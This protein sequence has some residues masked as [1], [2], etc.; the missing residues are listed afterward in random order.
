[1][2]LRTAALIKFFSSILL[3]GS[4]SV[5]LHAQ[6]NA[7]SEMISSTMGKDVDASADSINFI[8]SNILAKGHA[9]IRYKDIMV[10]A[11]KAIINITTKDIEA[12]GNVVFINRK[13]AEQEVDLWELDDLRKDNNLRV[14]II[15]YVTK[16]SGKQMIKVKLFRNQTV[17]KADRAIGNLSSGSVDFSTFICKSG[18]Y[19]CQG[20]RAERTPDG[21]IVIKDAKVTTCEYIMDGHEHYSVKA[22]S[23]TLSPRED[24]NKSLLDY[25]KDQGE[26]SMWAY[27][28]YFKLWDVPVFW[29]PALYKPA[30]AGGLG[31][32]VQGGKTTEYGYFV[33]T[34]KRFRWANDPDVSTKVMLDYYQL[35]G[36]GAG[37]DTDMYTATS[38][39]NLYFYY[40]HDREPYAGW[41]D[42]KDDKNSEGLDTPRWVER[43]AR[44]KTPTDRYDFRLSHM[45]HLTPRMD[46]RSQIEYIS[47]INYLKD[48]DEDR[49]NID[50]EPPTFSGLE[51]QFDRFST[52]LYV[53]PRINNYVSTVEKYPE[54]Q[55]NAP[56]QELFSNIYYQEQT[57][58]DYLKM[59]WREYDRPRTTGNGVDPAN[60]ETFR[61]DTIQMFYYPT[62]IDWLNI[63]PRA[64]FRLTEYSKS[65]KQ[66][67]SK[68]DLGTMLAVD[69][70]YDDVGGD[71]VN[72]D[73]KGGNKFR[74]AGETGVEMNTKLYRSWQNTKNAFWELDGLRHVAVPYVNYNYIPKP[75]ESADHLYYFDDTDRM[76]E[77][78]FVRVGLT[79][80]LQTRRGDYGNEVIY[81]WVSLENYM[82]FHFKRETGF[83][84]IGDLGS[85]LRFT[86]FPDL[87]LSSQ[88]IFDVGQNASHDTSAWR[89]DHY[90][91]RPGISWK[92]IDYLDSSFTY[93]INKDTKVYG[94]YVYQDNYWKRTTYSMGSTLSNMDGGTFFSKQYS[95]SQEAMLGYEM[96]TFFDDKTFIAAEVRYDFEQAYMRDKMIKIKRKMHCWEAAIEVGQSTKRDYMYDRVHSNRIIFSIYLT[97]SPAIGIETGKGKSGGDNN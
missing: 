70:P 81:D 88:A 28:T 75:T 56:R 2:A 32:E 83:N 36:I 62:N 49:Y 4:L 67:V 42:D 27:D 14:Q 96:P 21:T 10:T 74:M 31:I 94:S 78:N 58:L 91:G 60:Y 72:Y 90:D 64:G 77:Q 53:V 48:F 33:K 55:F 13:E 1:M 51:Y 82:D 12:I 24:S 54:F 52:S 35:R 92:Y 61:A 68:E 71:V 34:S 23:V 87:S 40:I 79:N 29:F 19:Y 93:R 39:T 11:D 43:N 3:I 73:N 25:N 86:P 69:N 15:D 89:G 47:D 76:I 44:I 46:F 8:G 95:R 97:A 17:M 6:D 65:S 57:S 30:E 59:N 18:E 7:L 45:Q 66:K 26:H 38:K 85:I 20:A 84:S 41:G 80:R 63:I 9:V 50:P 16:A 5:C 22:G 37:A